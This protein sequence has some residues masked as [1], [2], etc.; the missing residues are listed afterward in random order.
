MGLSQAP[1]PVPAAVPVPLALS[2]P[3]DTP[4]LMGRYDIA[5]ALQGIGAFGVGTVL[6]EDPAHDVADRV[7][8]LDRG[9][10]IA[11]GTPAAIRANAHVQAVYLGL[12]EPV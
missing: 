1:P 2:S 5:R 11:E 4:E 7:I 8:V 9:A 12:D 3:R 10:I 6:D